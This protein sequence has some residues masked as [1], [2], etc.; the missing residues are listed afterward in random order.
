MKTQL[1]DKLSEFNNQLAKPENEVSK[2]TII[3]WNELYAYF[4]NKQAE[5]PPIPLETI[6]QIKSKAFTNASGNKEISYNA[7]LKIL[8]S[9]QSQEVC[10]W[11]TDDGNI[12][13]QCSAIQMINNGLRYSYTYCPFC[14]K[15]IKRT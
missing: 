4:I 15:P 1:M 9:H 11:K 7:V 3:K 8:E 5:V 6:E 13:V 14:G 2:D 10:E 12:E